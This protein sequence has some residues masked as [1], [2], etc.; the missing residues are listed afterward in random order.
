LHP[1][2]VRVM[3]ERGIDIS[4]RRSKHLRRFSRTR[5]HRVITLCDK[6]KEICPEFP[7]PPATAHW[8]MPDPAAEGDGHDASC[9]AFRRT[10]DELDVRIALLIGELTAQTYERRHHVH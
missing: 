7:G 8:S 4:E 5:F 6:V 10:A 3:A 9:H 1:N 2:A